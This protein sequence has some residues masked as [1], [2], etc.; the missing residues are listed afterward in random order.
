MLQTEEEKKEDDGAQVTTDEN[1]DFSTIGTKGWNMIH[2]ACSVG[3]HEIVEFFLGPYQFLG[4]HV[5]GVLVAAFD[6][7]FAG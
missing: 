7:H 5:G 2:K 4:G 6:W 1:F 3:N